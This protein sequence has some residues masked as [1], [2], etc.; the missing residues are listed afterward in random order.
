MT[1]AKHES[2]D[3]N[4]DS[5]IVA[6]LERHWSDFAT[7]VKAFGLRLVHIRGEWL[8]DI[9]ESRETV[10]NELDAIRQSYRLGSPQNPWAAE[11]SERWGQQ[12][13]QDG[14]LPLLQHICPPNSKD[15]I[16]AKEARLHKDAAARIKAVT[17]A[18][19]DKH[20][21][22]CRWLECRLKEAQGNTYDL[23]IKVWHEASD[24]IGLELQRL[25]RKALSQSPR[26]P[27]QANYP[28]PMRV[29]IQDEEWVRAM[30]AWIEDV[31]KE[32][33]QKLVLSLRA[34]KRMLEAEAALRTEMVRTAWQCAQTQAISIARADEARHAHH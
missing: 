33:C 30:R 2:W 3:R 34:V 11:R 20:T 12:S 17:Q 32:S 22:H 10:K 26:Q 4:I 19:E 6:L 5:E 8:R 28:H 29:W 18:A 1:C 25:A 31:Q 15:R 21:E 16:L 13:Y 14:L 23:V 7:P 9:L 27:G 24:T